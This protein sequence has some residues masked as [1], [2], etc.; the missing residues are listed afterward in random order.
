MESLPRIAGFLVATGAVG[1]AAWW[2]VTQ[3]P[4]A[5]KADKPP[6]AVTVAKTVKEESLNSI[7][8]T[9]DAEKRL[10]VKL[11]SI[12]MKP[13]RRMRIYGGEVT[14]PAGKAIVVAAPLG[15]TLKAPPAGIPRAGQTVR[16]GQPIF[17]LLPLLSPEG[18]T[19][20][21]S[22]LVD[23]DG[24]V[25]NAQTQVDAAKI[26]LDRAKRL[27]KDG[28]GSQ[29]NVDET[30]AAFDLASKTLEAA[31]A[32]RTTLAKLVGEV[33]S[34]TAAPIPID[35]PEDGILRAI[36]A[37]PDQNV[38]SG[39]SL[40]EVIDLSIVWVRV[41]LPVGDLDEVSR[42]EPALVDKLSASP[43]SKPRQAKPVLAPPSANAV[44]ATV[45]LFYEMTND[46]GKLI[47][48]QR[49]G[50]AVSLNDATASLTVPWSAV[51][52]DIYG[53]NWVY[54]Q[55]AARTYARRRVVVRHVAGPD[56]VLENG[57]SPGVRVVSEGA[58]ELYGAETGFSK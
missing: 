53:G 26:A 44:S 17:Q 51:I 36:S 37:M 58:Q 7:V 12:E 54:E 41:A 46:G 20:M 24:Q 43:G 3:K 32:R 40:F 35:A 42:S 19:S 9:E 47:P 22:A 13:V 10:G 57:P 25:K 45:D 48:G 2:L 50:V 5:A 27:L 4:E 33:D 34:G 18:R 16:R 14:I 6:P 29:R 56:A 28:A 30:Q 1:F 23:A 11:G 39:A 31:T 21:A 8:L 52:F 38:P 15:G 55:T 49:L